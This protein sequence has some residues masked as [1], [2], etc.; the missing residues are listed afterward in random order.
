[1]AADIV[2][3]VDLSS[4]NASNI[5]GEKQKIKKEQTPIIHEENRNELIKK[6]SVYYE[7]AE[8]SFKSKINDLFKKE[9]AKPDIIE[10]VT[11]SI[12]IM[13]DRITRVNLAVTPPDVLI[14]PHLGDL[15]MLDF[16]QVEHTIEEGYTKAKE[17]IE[18][19]RILLETA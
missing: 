13:Q 9:A 15:K 7:N 10:T 18:D 6:L 1:M 14:Q 4:E 11:T 2:I 17:K 8:L 3:A 5:K 16:D 19:I 12:N